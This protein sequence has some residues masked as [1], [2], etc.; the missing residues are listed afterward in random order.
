MIRIEEAEFRE[1]FY[2][3]L[4]SEDF[5]EFGVVTGP[6]RSGAIASVYASHFLRIPFLPYGQESPDIG[7]LLI[8]DTAT[9]SGRTLRKALEKYRTALPKTI[10]AF[11]EPPRVIFWYERPAARFPH[12]RKQNGKL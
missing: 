4:S 3:L 11:H 6:G 8:V 10:A 12:Q 5:S 7:R 1:K 2:D 9:D